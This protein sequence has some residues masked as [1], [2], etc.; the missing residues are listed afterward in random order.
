MRGLN[1]EFVSR[2]R[3]SVDPAIEP[4]VGT[5]ARAQAGR[6][7]VERSCI[8]IC[9]MLAPQLVLN[10]IVAQFDCIV[11]SIDVSNHLNGILRGKSRL[12]HCSVRDS[13]LSKFPIF[14]LYGNYL[15][16]GKR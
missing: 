14:G 1:R 10:I 7:F 13:S 9:A 12:N 16:L 3:V 8:A 15:L 4:R 11:S 6:L 5:V 2:R